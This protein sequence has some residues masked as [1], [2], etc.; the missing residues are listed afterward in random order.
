[1]VQWQSPG[2]FQ[3]DYAICRTPDDLARRLI[4]A[5]SNEADDIA[6][7]EQDPTVADE[8]MR[9]AL[10]KA[11]CGQ[12]IFRKK[13][14]ER[15]GDACAVTNCGVRDLLR[16]S[17]IKPWRKSDNKER[18][19]PENGILLL[20]NIDILFDKGLVSF[21]DRGRLLVSPRLS[22]ADTRLLRLSGRLRRKPEERQR[23]YLAQH[24]KAFGF[25]D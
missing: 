18:L 5:P 13:L 15:W 6:A 16:A 25:P 14:D 8:T 24:R 23:A 1:V 7:I 9:D 4:L 17:H 22:A 19:D 10:I 20:A 11:R 21:D 3:R 2:D 12:G